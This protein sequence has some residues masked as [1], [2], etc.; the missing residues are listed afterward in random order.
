MLKVKLGDNKSFRFLDA[1]HALH[2]Y[3]YFLRDE[4]PQPTSK[5]SAVNVLLLGDEYTEP[6]H[7]KC[8]YKLDFM[9]P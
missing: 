7:S 4:N 6:L 1:S 2:A 9:C 3:N 8:V 5:K